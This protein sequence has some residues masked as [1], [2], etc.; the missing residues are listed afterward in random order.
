MS[1]PTPEVS[2]RIYRAL[3]E[4]L[5]K[6]ATKEIDVWHVEYAVTGDGGKHWMPS[7]EHHTLEMNARQSESRKLTEAAYRCVRVTGPHKQTVP[8]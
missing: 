2:A 8:A 5:S 4:H 7:I 1:A 6:P 3:R